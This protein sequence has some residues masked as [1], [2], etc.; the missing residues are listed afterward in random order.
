MTHV[1][2]APRDVTR[3]HFAAAP[4]LEDKAFLWLTIAASVAF[5]RI[6][7]PFAGA[8]L[9]GAVLAIVFVPLYRRLLSAMRQRRT[10]AALTTLLIILVMVIFPLTLVITALLRE[11]VSAYE[12][13][14]SGQLDFGLYLRQLLDALPAWVTRPLDRLGLTSLAAAVQTTLSSGLTKTLQFIASRALNIGQDTVGLVLSLLLVLYLLFFLLR[15]GDDMAERIDVGIPLRPELRRTL[16][17]TFTSVIRAT[18]K[19]SL[20]VAAA[21][22][23]LGG[24]MFWILGLRAPVLWGAV[25]ALASLLP[26]V[27]AGAVWVPMSIYLVATGAVWRGIA[28]ALYGALVIGTIDNI[29]RELLVHNDVKMPGY[30]V[31]VSTLGGIAVCGFNGVIIGPMIAAMFMTVW[32]I[33]SKS[34]SEGWFVRHRHSAGGGQSEWGRQDGAHLIRGRAGHLSGGARRNRF[35]PS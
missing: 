27:G 12:R 24:L 29:L 11:G 18:V 3:R 19:A 14:R 33:L 7:W 32:D 15:D 21:Q 28:L 10:L 35:R 20:V 6:L 5:A 25:M 13:I 34:R 26:A 4:S 9:W 8:I 30:L 2:V 23:A 31:L 22:G 1:T 17:G 16:A